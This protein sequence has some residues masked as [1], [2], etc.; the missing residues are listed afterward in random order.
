VAARI[1]SLR[2]RMNEAERQIDG[3]VESLLAETF[4]N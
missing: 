3:L 2:E 1:E 4:K